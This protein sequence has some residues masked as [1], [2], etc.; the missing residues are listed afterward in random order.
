MKLMLS[1]V[2]DRAIFNKEKT[3]HTIWSAI[4]APHMKN[5]RQFTC[6]I[7]GLD[8]NKTLNEKLI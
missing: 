2:G 6:E 1:I 8:Y 7:N 4:K 3:T 5:V